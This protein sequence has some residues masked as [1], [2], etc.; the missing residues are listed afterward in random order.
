MSLP[1]GVGVE[2][3]L[4]EATAVAEVDEYEAAVIAVGMHPAGE[5]DGFADVGDSELSAGM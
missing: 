2:D 1:A 4:R 3:Q 5:F